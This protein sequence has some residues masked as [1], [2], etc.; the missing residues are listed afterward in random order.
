[1]D[2]NS[3]IPVV[4][5]RKPN[6]FRFRVLGDD[7]IK[8]RSGLVVMS[9]VKREPIEWLWEPYIP[10]GRITILGGDPGAGKSFITTAISATLSRG[11][12][13]PGER[14]NI[15]E[16]MSI[17]MLNAEDDPADTLQPRLSNLHANLQKIF[18]SSED[19][20][21]DADGLRTIEEMLDETEA[22]L[23]IIDPIVAFLGPKVDMNRANEVRHIMKSIARIARKRN[24]AV[25]IVRHNRKAMAGAAA[26]K[27]IYN[28]MGSIDFTAAVRSELAVLEAP[29]SGV[30]FMNHIK[31]NSGKEG[32]SLI[33]EIEAL[34]DGTGLFHWKGFA[35]QPGH[36]SAS[37]ISRTFR[38][39]TKV[40]LWIHDTLKNSPDGLPT[41]EILSLGKLAGYSQTKLEHAKKGVALS[42]K[43]GDS[44]HWYL[45]PNGVVH[46]K[47][48]VIE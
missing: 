16:P 12:S 39:E 14:E 38:D 19:I 10:L 27:A 32:P 46:D 36:Q 40:K 3:E 42:T 9:E 31:A 24:I 1:M 44:W 7:K 13:L 41:N 48:G 28:G 30:K 37:T 8:M 22:K 45:D 17:L 21:L 34:D 5:S 18:V 33:Y 29:R 43:R 2:E 11:E 35:E 25:L 23:L 15:R 26:G 6:K 47:D 20:I 4:M